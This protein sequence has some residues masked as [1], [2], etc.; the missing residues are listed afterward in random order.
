MKRLIALAVLAA[1]PAAAATGPFFSLYNTDFVVL[2]AFLLFI[3]VLVY[4]K[5]PTLILGMLDKRA[6]AIESDLAEAR[7]LHEEARALLAETE[8]HHAEA[9]GEA[10]R[11][12]ERAREEAVAA[13]AEAKDAL[14]VSVARRLQAAEDQI[15]SAEAQAVRQVRNSAVSVAIAAASEVYAKQL[16]DADA[17]AMIDDAIAQVGSR[18]N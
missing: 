17:G 1:T 7:R 8:R 3:A 14:R 15:A 13:A 4:F 18:L 10:Q 2:L 12:I 6:A 5:V 9:R 11:I 16:S